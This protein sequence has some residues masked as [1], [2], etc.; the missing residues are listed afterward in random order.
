MKTDERLSGALQE[1]IL[2]LLC[3]DAKHAR[4]VRHSLTPQ[5]FESAVFREVAGIAIDFIDQFGEPVAEHLPDHLEHIL[6]GEDARK[7]KSYKRVLDDLFASRD[8]INGEYV[9]SQLHKFV[10]Q[11]NMKSAVLKVV[12]ALE[13]RRIDEAE[14]AWQKGLV[15]GV[16]AFEPGIDLADPAQALT[17]LQNADRPLLTGIE[18]LDRFDVGPAPK[19]LF[20]LT[21]ALGKGKSWGLMHLGRAALMQRKVVVHITLE[22]SAEK[23]VQRYMQMMFAVTKNRRRSSGPGV[24]RITK[25][26]DGSI[27]TIEFDDL[28][29]MGLLSLTDDDIH[30]Q[31]SRLVTRRLGRRAAFKVKKFSSGQLTVPGLNA[32]LDGLERFERIIP[33]V[34]IIDYAELM[35]LGEGDKKRGSIGQ[36]FVDLRGIADERNLSLITASQVNRPAIGK[37][38]NNETDLSEDISKGFTVDTMVTYN[39]TAMEERMGLARL[40]VAKNRDG[41]GK[42]TALITQAYA[43]GQFCTDSVVMSDRYLASLAPRVD[44]DDDDDERRPPPRGRR[45]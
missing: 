2:A 27:R 35:K 31:L 13:D 36:L 28:E 7:A 38:T 33:D 12:E 9:V 41:E 44:R 4:M 10:R 16:A 22:M 14:V 32:Y 21:G 42:M 29:K 45:R 23:T 1:N 37:T 30:G 40:F 8:G 34:L 26:F 24:P 17:F 15:S 20:L 3:F 19:T 18:A 5:H 43:M 6:K 39:Q 25:E 11:Q